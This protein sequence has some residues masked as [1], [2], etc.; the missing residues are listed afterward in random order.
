MSITAERSTPE[1]SL[2]A[3][4]FIEKLLLWLT[5]AV[6][7]V[8]AVLYCF[9]AI[10]LWGTPSWTAN[11]EPVNIRA[12]EDKSASL[13]PP[14]AL[15]RLAPVAPAVNWETNLSAQPFWFLF[16]AHP[17]YGR[18]S[19]EMELPSRHAREM[20]CWDKAN[21]ASLGFANRLGSAGRIRTARAGFVI[22]LRDNPAVVN[23]LC[24]ATFV[25]PA[26][27]SVVQWSSIQFE[28]SLRDFSID[29]GMLEGGMAVMAILLLM[30]AIANR[31]LTYLLGATWV[32]AAM[33]LSEIS[34]GSEFRWFNQQLPPHWE[35]VLRPLSSAL[36]FVLTA[37]LS[38]RF[39]RADLKTRWERASLGV[40]GWMAILILASATILPS[41]TRL[42]VLWFASA[43]A[44]SIIA[45]IAVRMLALRSSI[46]E[47]AFAA[48]I[49]VLIASLY[50]D[51]FVFPEN[52]RTRLGLAV[53][54]GSALLAS[55]F[56]TLA[57]TEHLRLQRLRQ[58]LSRGLVLDLCQSAP[59]AIFSL[60]M[61]GNFRYRN[62]LF[63]QL[64]ETGLAPARQDNW[65]SVFG[66]AAWANLHGEILRSAGAELELH[67]QSEGAADTQAFV[68]SAVA[69]GDGIA[70]NVRPRSP[71][72]VNDAWRDAAARR[73]QD[74][75]IPFD[76]AEST[77]A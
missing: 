29:E 73:R 55:L 68:L 41:D 65:Q 9:A 38:F 28:K 32:F 35:I 40:L 5:V 20:T 15:D 19:V 42:P 53:L 10:F 66:E 64:L 8:G 69:T 33:R 39:F 48:A 22:D 45:I 12:I 57:I 58:V 11:G 60:D 51:T 2:K 62:L 4:S 70:G 14:G 63:V 7:P 24:R 61:Q 23:I 75:N 16:T 13:T 1:P 3:G 6:I 30:L 76:P 36:L 18:D 43:V 54:P 47:I 49:G 50:Y 56:V 74:Q 21:L 44:V 52:L 59:L 37:A 72:F 26:H 25:G 71:A 34:L 17:D 46:V 31:D 77:H 27:I 67:R